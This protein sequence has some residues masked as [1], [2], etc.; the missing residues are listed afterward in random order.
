MRRQRLQVRPLEAAHLV[1]FKAQLRG[2][3]AD[4]GQRL[5][6]EQPGFAGA[7]DALAVGGDVD[8]GVAGEAAI[9]A[10]LEEVADEADV[11]ERDGAE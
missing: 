3:Q 2:R 5:Q 7:A 11:E 10:E 8:D 9:V 4:V 1:V 6:H